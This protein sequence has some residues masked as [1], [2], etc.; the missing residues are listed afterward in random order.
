MGLAAD[1]ADELVDAVRTLAD[2]GVD[3][4]KVMATGGMM[5]SSSNP[6]GAQYTDAQLSAL[7]LEARTADEAGRGACTVGGWRARCS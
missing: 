6:Y 3:F 7:V 4:I 5:T 2:E 1:T